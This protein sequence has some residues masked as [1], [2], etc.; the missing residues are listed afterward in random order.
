MPKKD[1]NYET[2]VYLFSNKKWMNTLFVSI[3]QKLVYRNLLFHLKIHGH[4][5]V[6]KSAFDGVDTVFPV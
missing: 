5:S 6:V 4:I 1:L 2:K 3:H